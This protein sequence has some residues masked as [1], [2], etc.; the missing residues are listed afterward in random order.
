MKPK[1]KTLSSAKPIKL[2]HCAECNWEQEIIGS[3][4]A[5]LE[6]C[7]WCGWSDLE[8][9]KVSEKGFFQ[10]IECAEHGRIYILLPTTDIEEQDFMDNLFCP[11]CK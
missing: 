10:E 3:T 5:K 8:T 4:K 1:V 9:S 11:Y 7:P 2:I 6:S